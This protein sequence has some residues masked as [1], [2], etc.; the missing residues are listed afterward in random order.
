MMAGIDTSLYANFLRPPKTVADYDAEAQASRANMLAGIGEMMKMREMTRQAEEGNAL[1]EVFQPQ[2]FDPFSQAGQAAILKASPRVGAEITQKLASTLRERRQGEEAASKSRRE[3]AHAKIEQYDFTIQRA[4]AAST[5]QELLAYLDPLIKNGTIPQEK[6]MAA[7]RMLLSGD[8]KAFTDFKEALHK[9]GM[10][11][12][13]QEKARLAWEAEQRLVAN[14]DVTIGADG[15]WMPNQ[16]AIAAHQQKGAADRAS[17]EGIA[18]REESG[19]WGRHG[20][21][22]SKPQYLETSGGMMMLPGKVKAGEVPTPVLLRDPSSGEPLTKPAK[23]L[24]PA[25]AK[26]KDEHI[27]AIGAVENLDK[28]LSTW[29]DKVKTG[30]LQVGLVRNIAGQARN[31]MG[32]SDANSVEF[33]KFK[34]SL[35]EMRNGVLLLHK[36]V[37]T[38]GD[39][40]RAMDQI[41]ANI[42]DQ[43]VVAAQLEKLRAVNRDAVSVRK[44]QLKALNEE[45]GQ[46]SQGGAA[47][48]GTGFPGVTPEAIAAEAERRRKARG[49]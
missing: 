1:R 18:A 31:F 38:E 11:V 37:Q 22:I 8:Q 49:E 44:Q 13:E 40:V 35:E 17:R 48:A 28:R 36:G 29:E 15:K 20:A 33:A 14:A 30:K 23:P 6:A 4:S 32:K 16:Q 46:R 5:P 27:G 19:R 25:V 24:P 9:S 2:D 10:K 34:S 39:A 42:N 45:Y 43:K 47:P 21:E 12:V 3:D 7:S 41:M 26:L